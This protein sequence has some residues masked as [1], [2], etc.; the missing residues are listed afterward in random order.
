MVAVDV[1]GTAVMT[2]QVMT[3]SDVHQATDGAAYELFLSAARVGWRISLD[4]ATFADDG[5]LLIGCGTAAWSARWRRAGAAAHRRCRFLR[6]ASR[7]ARSCNLRDIAE[8]GDAT[9][10]PYDDRAFA[11]CATQ[12]VLNF[13]PNCEA[14]VAEMR[15]DAAA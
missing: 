10:L 3:S 15:A 14:A 6:S 4:F 9:A 8:H 7:L 2:L 1:T 12:L 5:T 13:I 11:G